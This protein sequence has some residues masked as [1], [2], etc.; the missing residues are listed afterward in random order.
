MSSVFY[1]VFDYFAAFLFKNNQL[2]GIFKRSTFFYDLQ[3]A[4]VLNIFVQKFSFY[5]NL[6]C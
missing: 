1:L 6:F 4:N 5:F 2:V 3:I